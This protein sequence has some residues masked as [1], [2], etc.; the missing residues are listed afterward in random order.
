[1]TELRRQ[2][3]RLVDRAPGPGQ[4][5]DW[6]EIAVAR[7]PGSREPQPFGASMYADALDRV[8]TSPDARERHAARRFMRSFASDY[9]TG[10]RPTYGDRKTLR[11]W[12]TDA[13]DHRL[14]HG[15]GR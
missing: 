12:I 4:I 1:M 8:L 5:T 9:R 2:S 10:A 11:E 3:N 13:I 14:D 7:G 15:P 6:G